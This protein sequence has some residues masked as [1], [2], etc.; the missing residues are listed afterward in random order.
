MRDARL[1]EIAVEIKD[2]KVAC[3]PSKALKARASSRTHATGD[4]VRAPS[5]PVL[6]PDLFFDEPLVFPDSS[7][8]TPEATPSSR[9]SGTPA[10]LYYLPVMH[11]QDFLCNTLDFDNMVVANAA[12]EYPD[13]IEGSYGQQA[14]VSTA[15]LFQDN[16]AASFMK[17]NFT[18]NDF[19]NRQQTSAPIALPF[20]DNAGPSFV[21]QDLTTN[22]VNTITPFDDIMLLPAFNR[23]NEVPNSDS[24]PSFADETYLSGND[25]DAPSQF[26]SEGDML[27]SNTL[28]LGQVQSSYD[29]SNLEVA[30]PDTDSIL[31]AGDQPYLDHF[32]QHFAL[33]PVLDICTSGTVASNVVLPAISFNYTVLQNALTVAAILKRAHNGLAIADITQDIYRFR[34]NTIKSLIRSLTDGTEPQDVLQ[35]V[36]FSIYLQLLVGSCTDDVPNRPWHL[37]LGEHANLV[38]QSWHELS[39][40]AQN[41]QPLNTAI[42]F[43]MDIQ[44][45]VIR[46]TIPLFLP[47]YVQSLEEGLAAGLG[48][49]MGCDDHVMYTIAEIAGLDASLSDTVL[50]PGTAAFVSC[51]DRIDELMEQ[52]H[53]GAQHGGISIFASGLADPVATS[54]RSTVTALYRIVAEIYLISLQPSSNPLEDPASTRLFD[55][56]ETFASLMKAIPNGPDGLDSSLS[57]LYLIAGSYSQPRS[58]F[59][60]LFMGRFDQIGRK[61]KL[62]NLVKVKD[63]LM[64]V[65]HH[66]DASMMDGT[67][68]FRHWRH[69]MRENRQGR[70]WSD[71]LFL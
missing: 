12:S 55:L 37:E 64:D 34:T 24:I 22:D 18:P 44:G 19:S 16:A 4:L 48:E 39:D 71:V 66:N 25:H 61:A 23:Q 42:A 67:R 5:L 68:V 13:L 8:Y 60:T 3:K 58:T 69:V 9:D 21:S 62:G 52:L 17:Q 38:Y 43:W 51:W 1:A 54:L 20:R 10:Y 45:A 47:T 32:L 59:R 46:R 29:T 14:S 56:L 57:W 31:P 35:S 63:I 30:M 33:F 15:L 70:D 27:W 41:L 11:D 49:V 7:Y 36:L 53:L 6:A 65:W 40:R 28:E 26:F 50:E 2:N